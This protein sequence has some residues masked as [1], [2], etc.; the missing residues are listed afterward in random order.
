MNVFTAVFQ[1]DQESVDAAISIFI[2]TFGRDTW[3]KYLEYFVEERGVRYVFSA[4]NTPYKNFFINTLIELEAKL[5]EE[6]PEFIEQYPEPGQE[7]KKCPDCGRT[8]NK[9]I[10]PLDGDVCGVCFAK[11]LDI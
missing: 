6:E 9:S 10:F 11:S 7:T 3:E 4:L 5:M 2:K 8:I 1:A